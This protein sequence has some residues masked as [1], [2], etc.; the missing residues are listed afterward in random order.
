MKEGGA[1]TE[2]C[3]GVSKSIKAPTRVDMEWG[4]TLHGTACTCRHGSIAAEVDARGMQPNVLK[5]LMD[6]PLRKA[7]KS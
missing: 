1:E 3:H 4:A 7:L 5:T 2:M 6:L